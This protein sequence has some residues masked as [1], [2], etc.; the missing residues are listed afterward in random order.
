MTSRILGVTLRLSLAIVSLLCVMGVGK[1]SPSVALGYVPK[2]R[3]DYQ[4][5]DYVN[6]AAPKGGSLTLS[7]FGNFDSLNPFLLR[8][9]SA[10]GLSQLVFET[11]MVQSQDEPY[12]LYAHLA[13]DIA[14]A[15][16]GLSVTFELDPRAHF[17]DG[18]PVLA[19]D[20]KFSFDT[21]KSDASDP[22]Y[23]FYWAAITTAT[24]LG[25]RKIRF[26]FAQRNPELHLI[27]AQM[28]VFARKWVGDKDFSRL[29]MVKPLA[30]G[31]YVVDEYHLGKDI[32]FRRDPHYWARDLPSR[33][34]MYN[35][36]RVIFKYYKDETVRLE[37]MKAGEYDF[38]LENHSKMWARDYTG[39]QFDSGHIK[40]EELHHRN[41]AGMQGFVFNLRRDLFKDKRVR[42]ALSLA[43]DFAWSNKNLFYNQ[44]VRCDSYFSN[45]EL[46]SSGVP[47]GAE[48]RLLEKYAR[49]LDPDIFTTAW[50][51]PRS[52]TARELRANLIQAKNLLAQAGWR[53]S[54][55]VLKNSKGEAFEFEFILAQ[56]GFERILGPYAY[57]LKKLGITM[58]YRTVDVSIYSDRMRNFN[59]DMAVASYPESQSPGNEQSNM[60]SSRAADQ[61]GSRNLIGVK[62]PAV[63]DLLNEV[64]YS[65]DRSHLLTAVHAL[66]RVLLH[67]EYLVP[68]W[69]INVHRVAYWNKFGRPQTLPL[70]Y[71]ADSW[72]LMSWWALPPT[73][74]GGR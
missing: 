31:P 44:Y 71:E 24:V 28:P 11:L 66:D 10:D 42:K 49:L 45:S 1:A 52:D 8:G 58:K 60:W 73:Q 16:D 56:K 13:R 67:G 36:D 17:S 29:S 27:V 57:N 19:G 43:F 22:Q 34:G 5:F 74:G 62:D 3:S 33:R 9:V 69:Y 21:L 4:H 68:N 38:V 46:A 51:P 70:Y 7:G 39:P 41:N 50:A 20:V 6:P 40:R 12:S 32:I 18:S 26:S 14:L 63:D 35:F 55:G 23:R 59:F 48:L 54:D 37:A 53:V 2:Y 65:S 64:I 15:P 47:Q 61:P 25:P 30:S 72:A